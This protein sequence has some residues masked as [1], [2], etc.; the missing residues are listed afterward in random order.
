MRRIFVAVTGML[1][2]ATRYGPRYCQ[3][4]RSGTTL[5]AKQTDILRTRVLTYEDYRQF[6]PRLRICCGL[7][8]QMKCVRLCPESYG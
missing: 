1:W 5:R 7:W 4:P 2:L 6:H 8:A 3:G